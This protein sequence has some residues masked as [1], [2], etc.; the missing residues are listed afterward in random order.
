MASE[1]KHAAVAVDPDL[2]AMVTKIHRNTRDHVLSALHSASSHEEQLTNVLS[3]LDQIRRGTVRI[4]NSRDVKTI[5]TIATVIDERYKI[6]PKYITAGSYGCAYTPSVKCKGDSTRSPDKVSKLMHRKLADIEENA[7]R[8]L[9]INDI[10][11]KQEFS[12]NQ[13]RSCEVQGSEAKYL[14]Q[15]K[16]YKPLLGA[17][18]LNL[19]EFKL[20]QY[21][22]GGTPLYKRKVTS[23]TSQEEVGKLLHSLENIFY[24]LTVM[25]K[26]YRYHCDVKGNNIVC[27]PGGCRLIDFGLACKIDPT[28]DTVTM[29]DGGSHMVR[30]FVNGGMYKHWPIEVNLLALPNEAINNRVMIFNAVSTSVAQNFELLD[31]AEADVEIAYIAD[32]HADFWEMDK[33]ERKYTA[34]VDELTD[35]LSLMSRTEIADKIDTYGLGV[36]LI[37][38]LIHSPLAKSGPLHELLR[39]MTNPDQPSRLN[40][41]AAYDRYIDVM[42]SVFNIR[43]D[44][45]PLTVDITG[46]GASALPGHISAAHVSAIGSALSTAAHVTHSPAATAAHPSGTGAGAGAAAGE[47]DAML[48]ADSASVYR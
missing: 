8:Y 46:R 11:P 39:D 12:I 3:L 26:N 15:C 32:F 30:V 40:S 19:A 14:T 6:L 43:I 10:D 24:G 18:P 34:Y 22:Y 9:G 23:A 4:Y 31:H 44:K 45:K 17:P 42:Q 48:G 25:N 36:T 16:H 2:N 37:A 41:E 28:T 13:P 35:K 5:R 38:L 1:H 47:E 27:L 33:D 29:G 7:L 21:D 20:L